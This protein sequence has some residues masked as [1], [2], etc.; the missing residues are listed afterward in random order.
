[1]K[2]TVLGLVIVGLLAGCSSEQTKPDTSQADAARAAA[3]KAAA[4]KAAA[5]AAAKAAAEARAR[6]AALAAQKINPLD[7]P[8]NILSQRSVY[9]AFD[10]YNVGSEYQPML[11]AHAKYIED[12]SNAK[13]QLQGNCDDRGSV[14]YNLA[15]GQRR[16]DSVRKSLSLLG[17][18]EAQMSSISFGKSKPRA[19][20]ENE[21]AWAQNRRTDIVY[22]S[23]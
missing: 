21:T 15:L 14:E 11:Q 2:K 7:D 23:E 10:K 18:P 13:V 22:Q 6:E 19:Q 12:H 16:A 9:F 17:A 3:A 1:M 4:D 5:D 20:G 8:N